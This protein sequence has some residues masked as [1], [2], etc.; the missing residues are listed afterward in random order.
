MSRNHQHRPLALAAIL[1]AGLLTACGGGGGGPGQP[2]DDTA[3]I[4]AAIGGAPLALS[5]TEIRN[6]LVEIERRADRLDLSDDTASCSGTGCRLPAGILYLSDF[7]LAA[8]SYEPVMTRHGIDV[9][10]GV[11]RITFLGRTLTYQTYGGWG[12]HVMFAG[13]ADYDNDAAVAFTAGA[14]TGSRPTDGTA[15]WRGVMVGGDWGRAEAFQG[16]ALLTAD[17]GAGSVDV[18]FTNIHEIETG[19]ARND[20]RFA[21]VPFTAT[22]FSSGARIGRFVEGSFYGPAHAEAGGVF[23]TD[24]GNR[25]GAFGA[26]RGQ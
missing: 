12:D 23:E 17:F 20:I 3:T 25:F 14:T 26:R 16:D 2:F 19:G 4:R 8:G 5:G 6:E 10:Q 9:M 18:A 24:G 11:N 7:Q 13:A 22:G 1:T 21:N 15:T